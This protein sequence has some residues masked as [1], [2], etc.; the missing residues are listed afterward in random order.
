MN[1]ARLIPFVTRLAGSADSE[2]EDER[3]AV[4]EARTLKHIVPV[5]ARV[6]KWKV[7]ELPRPDHRQERLRWAAK[8]AVCAWACRHATPE[9][10]AII[11]RIVAIADAAMKIGKQA[12]P[13]D[14]LSALVRLENARPQARRAAAKVA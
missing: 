12:E 4:I 14:P 11:E 6:S 8:V 5:V 9:G 1:H 3:L 2:V 13:I 10:P 7:E